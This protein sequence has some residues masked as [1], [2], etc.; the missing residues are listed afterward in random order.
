MK[1]LA[2]SDALARNL[3]ERLQFRGFAVVSSRDA[4]GWPK[5]NLNVDEASLTIIAADAVSTDIF[6]NALVAFAPHRI[7]FASRDNA[8]STLKV[9]EIQLE[10]IKMG[11]E[12][13]VVQTHATVLATAEAAAGTALTFDVQWPT[14]GI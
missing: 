3:A 4:N 12:K 9:S 5:L 7:Q 6:G 1:S 14:K 11:V 2:K 10:V 13:M 8:M